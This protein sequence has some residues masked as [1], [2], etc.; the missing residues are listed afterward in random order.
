[1]C[2]V[3]RAPVSLGMVVGSGWRMVGFV[4]WKVDV[5]REGMPTW[6]V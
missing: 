1:M 6:V 4:V 5:R 2:G 3:V